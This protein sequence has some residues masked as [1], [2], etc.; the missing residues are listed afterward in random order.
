MHNLISRDVYELRIFFTNCQLVCFAR[1]DGQARYERSDRA[2]PADPNKT[3]S[4][5]AAA[6]MKALQAK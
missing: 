3:F 2:S 6:H 4:K 5:V 1:R